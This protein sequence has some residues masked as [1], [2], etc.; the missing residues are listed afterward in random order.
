MGADLKTK[1]FTRWDD[2]ETPWTTTNLATIGK[3]IVA[4][5]QPENYSSTANKYIYINSYTIT[6]NQL[7]AS[8]QKATGSEWTLKTVQSKDIV[9][10][11]H[12]DIKNGNI[13]DAIYPLIQAS[14]LGPVSYGDF[15]PSGFSNDAFGLPKED[16]DEDVKNVLK[17]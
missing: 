1:T 3:G 14:I 4:L 7:L 9:D 8:L 5:L 10:K 11:A 6:Q 12:E 2:G 13:A 15:R 17:A 16:L